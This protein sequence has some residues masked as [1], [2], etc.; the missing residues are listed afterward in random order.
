MM[1]IQHFNIYESVIISHGHN[2]LNGMKS[3]GARDQEMSREIFGW[4]L[5]HVVK[6]IYLFIYN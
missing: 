4:K 6:F 2:M 3:M 1:R 5:Y